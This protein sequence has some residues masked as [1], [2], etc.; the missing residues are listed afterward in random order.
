MKSFG[1]FL[2][3]AAVVMFVLGA[4]PVTVLA[5]KQPGTVTLPAKKGNV[6]FHHDKHAKDRKIKCNTCH[7]KKV[8]TACKDCH[9]AKKEGDT[10]KIKNAF[11][12]TCKGCH[13]KNKKG[14]TKCK[15]CHKK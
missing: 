10:P 12:K 8:G 1:Q 7:H 3:A 5:K 15:D 2:A 9:K 4:G 11:H 13:K 14:P 6:T